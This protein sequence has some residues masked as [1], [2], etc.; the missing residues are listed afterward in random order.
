MEIRFSH[1][2]V[3]FKE[4]VADVNIGSLRRTLVVEQT[5]HGRRQASESFLN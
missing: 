2:F 4:T 3:H 5:L 1:L